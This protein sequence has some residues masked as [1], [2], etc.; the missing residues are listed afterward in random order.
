VVRPP[1]GFLA[2]P[3]RTGPLG[4]RKRPPISFRPRYGD[5]IGVNFNGLLVSLSR[6]QEYP[7]DSWKRDQDQGA[8]DITSGLRIDTIIVD[9]N[10][11]PIE[12]AATEMKHSKADVR[13]K[14]RA[15]LDVR[16]EP[17]NLT[18]YWDLIL[19]QHLFSLIG[20][21]ERLWSC[22]GHL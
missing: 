3:S 10:E 14:S 17:Q 8:A 6:T 4:S 15:A 1:S 18:L 11:I 21:K 13:G 2:I 16:F 12:V 19:F 20:I 22:F 5:V 7:L 9:Q